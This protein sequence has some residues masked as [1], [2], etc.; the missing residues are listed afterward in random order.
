MPLKNNTIKANIQH[1]RSNIKPNVMR[2]FSIIV[3]GLFSI[4]VIADVVYFLE[5]HY[6]LMSIMPR[7]CLQHWLTRWPIFWVYTTPPP[8]L[9]PFSFPEN[10]FNSY[11][12]LFLL[13]MRFMWLTWAHSK[14]TKSRNMIDVW[15]TLAQN[16]TFFFC[17]FFYPKIT[18]KSIKPLK[19]AKRTQ[20]N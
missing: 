15:L 18:Q 10:L 13:A 14:E 16:A 6:I 12:P 2:Y 7:S 5:I 8:P 1:K 17:F 9:W 4:I 3:Y 20:R 11:S 19:P